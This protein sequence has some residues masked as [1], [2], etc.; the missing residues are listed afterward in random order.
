MMSKASWNRLERKVLGDKSGGFCCGQRRLFNLFVHWEGIRH[1]ILF[2]LQKDNKSRRFTE[3]PTGRMLRI[4]GKV[5]DN[6]W[7]GDDTFGD[8]SLFI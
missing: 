7:T 5:M 1:R 8:G 2:W 3:H 6:T 4:Y